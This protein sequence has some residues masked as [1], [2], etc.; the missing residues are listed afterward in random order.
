MKTELEMD[1]KGNVECPNCGGNS[2]YILTRVTGYFGRSSMFNAGK[3]GEL[4]DRE[5]SINGK[6]F[7]SN[8]KNE[9]GTNLSN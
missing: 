1:N 7:T 2:A 8:N 9:Q 4:R 5:K 3:L 6:Y